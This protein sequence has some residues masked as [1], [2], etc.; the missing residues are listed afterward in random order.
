MDETV[1]HPDVPRL[2]VRFLRDYARLSQIK[3]GQAARV[4]QSHLSELEQGDKVPSEDVLRRLAAAAGF[5]WP[6][7]AHLRRFYAALLAAIPQGAAFEK[8]TA[9]LLMVALDDSAFLAVH[10]YLVERCDPEVP[11]DLSEQRRRNGPGP[12]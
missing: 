12:L 7:V 1:E 8:A 4:R 5:P 10:S 3:L 9:D 6:L 2:V 11:S